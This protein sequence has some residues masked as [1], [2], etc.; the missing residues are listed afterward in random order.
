LRGTISTAD[1]VPSGGMHMQAKAAPA[2]LSTRDKEPCFL[3]A[4]AAAAK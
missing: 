2:A 3:D 4:R 1:P